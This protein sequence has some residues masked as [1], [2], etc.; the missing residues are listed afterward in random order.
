MTAPDGTRILR[1][2]MGRRW[3]VYDRRGAVDRR[4]SV[5]GEIT[6]RIFVAEDGETRSYAIGEGDTTESGT[7][8]L[9]RQLARAT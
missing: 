2:T 6:D 1:D 8:V 4:G 9:E 5:R 7:A 3:M